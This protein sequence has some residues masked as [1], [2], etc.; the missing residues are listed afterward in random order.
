M[1]DAPRLRRP[2]AGGIFF[3]TLSPLPMKKADPVIAL[4]AGVV[5]F[6]VSA[7][8]AKTV[9][10]IYLIVIGILGLVKK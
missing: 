3:D 6:F 8:L 2:P 10:A 9:I 7:E 1:V 4:V 5:L